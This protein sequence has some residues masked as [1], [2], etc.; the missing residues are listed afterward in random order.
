[1]V[2]IVQLIHDQVQSVR[3]K[4]KSVKVCGPDRVVDYPLMSYRQCFLL[5]ASEATNI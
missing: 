5:G 2:D 1:M 4:N 3:A